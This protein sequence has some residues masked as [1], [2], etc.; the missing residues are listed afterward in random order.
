M[1]FSLFYVYSPSPSTLFFFRF[2]TCALSFLLS[3][4][5]SL[6]SICYLISLFSSPFL[7]LSSILFLYLPFSSSLTYFH[8]PVH[9]PSPS[10]SLSFFHFAFSL[11][12][13][14]LPQFFLLSLLHYYFNSSRLSS[15]LI[16]S[17]IRFASSPQLLSFTLVLSPFIHFFSPHIAF[18]LFSRP[19][20]C[21]SYLSL[22]TYYSFPSFISYSAPLPYNLFSH[23][24]SPLRGLFPLLS[25]ST[26][27]IV[28]IPLQFSF[29]SSMLPHHSLLYPISL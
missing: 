24:P 11:I 5:L 26:S 3:C 10:P 1:A 13:I 16:A 22:L 25:R 15:F 18:C 14:L 27:A 21:S 8:L 6:I 4:S 23:F 17:F 12:S 9:S 7:T 19:L 28:S 29:Y 2:L 20:P